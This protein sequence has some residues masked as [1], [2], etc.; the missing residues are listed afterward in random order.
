MSGTV[1]VLIDNSV[2]VL[3]ISNPGRKN[4]L[5][6]PLV[7]DLHA[8]CARVETDAGISAVVIQG[9]DGYFCSGADT[10]YL[11]DRKAVGADTDNVTR[12]DA[13]YASFARLGALPV[14][15]IAAIRGG[16]VGA[17]MNLALAADVRIVADDARLMSGFGRIGL[18]PGG[19]HAWLLG[20]AIGLQG[21]AAMV[22]LGD[23]ISGSRAAELGLAWQALP[24]E[25]VESGAA[26]IAR[27]TASDPELIRR[28]TVTL[29]QSIGPPAL[30]WSAALDIER[31]WQLWS[32]IRRT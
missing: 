22:L 29:R 20:R 11:A 6:P 23:E 21:A 8:A 19:G 26:H 30:P 7:D 5:S 15:V 28:M 27:A 9:A 14:P 4:A 12:G 1:E 16:A 17:G 31:T 18:H 3:T 25:S 24:D 10:K 2:C 13:T 32:L